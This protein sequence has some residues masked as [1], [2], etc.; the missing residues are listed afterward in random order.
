[1]PCPLEGQCLFLSEVELKNYFKG[2]GR[3]VCRNILGG[4]FFYNDVVFFVVW[5]SV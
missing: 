3:S 5:E 2:Y 1:M 4:L